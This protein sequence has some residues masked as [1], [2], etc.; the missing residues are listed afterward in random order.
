MPNDSQA[1]TS[2]YRILSLDGGGSW[3]LIQIRALQALFTPTTRGHEVLKY[4]NL[5]VANSGGSIA[6]MALA[7]NHTLEEIVS[8][9]K[10]P[11]K[12]LQIFV[13][14]KRFRRKPFTDLIKRLTGIGPRYKA[15]EKLKGFQALFKGIGNKKLSEL[16]AIIGAGS[17]HFMIVAYDYDRERAA[18]F[19]SDRH[20]KAQTHIIA[21]AHNLPTTSTFDDLTVAQAL[22]ASSN[23][24]LNF[25]D[26]PAQFTFKGS[27]HTRRFWDGA[28][29]GYNNPV[30]AGI[31][32]ALSNGIA[33]SNIRVLSIGT[34]NEFLPLKSLSAGAPAG[35]RSYLC[36]APTSS[37]LKND[38]MK[39]ALSILSDPPDAA[40]YTAYTLLHGSSL[41]ER[42]HLVRMNPL[43]Q[44]VERGGDWALPE[45]MPEADFLRLLQL[46]LDAVAQQDIE[47][48]DRF[49]SLWLQ[50]KVPNQPIRSDAQLKPI[51]GHGWFREARA[52]FNAMLGVEPPVV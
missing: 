41:S 15:T 8:L 45:G 22:H 12:R 16:P 40:S 37:T 43:I 19:R 2:P 20:S 3:A 18:F 44:P 32:E 9:Y 38:I 48:I 24:P 27:A 35:A 1:A 23:A 4:F 17:P 42:P 52:A 46:D 21:Q 51:L 33:L 36:K 11:E 34:G 50:S 5:V 14:L 13:D 31:T 10:T 39:M 30:M 7:E 49:C 6:A 26:E 47:L 28:V 25:F 29:G